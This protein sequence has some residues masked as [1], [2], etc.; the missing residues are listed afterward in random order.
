MEN[1]A[2]I[3]RIRASTAPCWRSSASCSCSHRA[4]QVE[5][6]RA[7]LALLPVRRSAAGGREARRRQGARPCR[8]ALQQI[9]VADLRPRRPLRHLPPGGRLEG[10]RERPRSR[11]RTHPV[12]PLKTHPIEKFGCTSCHGGQGWAI[13]TAAAHGEV[14]HWEEPLLEP[15]A[16]RGVLARRQQGRADADEL[17]R[18]PPLRPRDQGRRRDQ[19]GQAARQREGLPRLPRDQRLRRHDRARPHRRRRQGARAVRHEPA[20]GPAHGVCVA[21][22]ALQGPAGAR[23]PTR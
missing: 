4:V 12:E 9:W 20:V 1:S 13:D 3:L 14:A 15:R 5:R 11:M 7:R 23:R 6:P 19:P 8:A 17:Q 2:P 10:L 22:R 18:L 21:R 16:R